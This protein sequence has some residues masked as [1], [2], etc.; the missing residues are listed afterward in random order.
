MDEA[1]RILSEIVLK[2]Y[3]CG[4]CICYDMDRTECKLRT[5]LKQ[6]YPDDIIEQAMAYVK[7]FGYVKTKNYVCCAQQEQQEQKEFMH[8]SVRKGVAKERLTKSWKCYE[9]EEERG[10]IQKFLKKRF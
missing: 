1:G 8:H 7:S 9:M 6:D 10:A 3:D 5:K 2:R 4:Q